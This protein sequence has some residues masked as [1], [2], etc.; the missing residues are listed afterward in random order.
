MN[1][2]NLLTISRIPLTVVLCTFIEYRIWPA[3]LVTFVVA[4]LTDWIDGWWAR[5]VSIRCPPS[6]ASSIR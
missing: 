2:P 3:A 5:Q 1:V 6:A 4:A